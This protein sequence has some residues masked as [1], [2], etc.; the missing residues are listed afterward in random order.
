M[1]MMS[2]IPPQIIT[3]GQ[4]EFY[5]FDA[6]ILETYGMPLQN[7]AN[8]DKE[9][10]ITALAIGLTA[11]AHNWGNDEE[12]LA[13]I[14]NDDKLLKAGCSPIAL[15]KLNGRMA[16]IESFNLEVDN[17]ID[18]NIPDQN[19]P[20]QK[21]VVQVLCPQVPFVDGFKDEETQI[22]ATINLSD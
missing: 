7:I 17:A 10:A 18:R 11:V 8:Q 2:E 21:V 12:N 9:L 15:R 5:I 1:S 3:L 22:V 16:Y 6:A 4:P 13:L 14:Y 20:R 19:S